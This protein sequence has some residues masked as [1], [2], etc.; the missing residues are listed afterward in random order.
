[1]E[2]DASVMAPPPVLFL[3]AWI[4]ASSLHQLVP[5]RIVRDLARARQIAG[6]TAAAGGV[7]LSALVVQRF[8]RAS[9]PVSPLRATRA[10]VTTGP[11]RYSRNPDY[12]GQ[13]GIFIGAAIVSNRLWPVLVLPAVLSIVRWTVI[14]REEQYLARLFGDAY[15]EYARRVPRWI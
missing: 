15:R 6:G 12:L 13:A 8:A 10:L 1:M 9:T 5:L 3:G 14:E 7:C 11:Y 2:D 4:V